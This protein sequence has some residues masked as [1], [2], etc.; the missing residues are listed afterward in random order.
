[1]NLEEVSG[2]KTEYLGIGGDFWFEKDGETVKRSVGSE[3][4]RQYF[5]SICGNYIRNK[6]GQY[7]GY[8]SE[9]GFE[10]R[11]WYN[12]KL[13]LGYDSYSVYV[14]G[15]LVR[16]GSNMSYWTFPTGTSSKDSSAVATDGYK[17]LGVADKLVFENKNKTNY[18]DNISVYSGTVINPAFT[19]D[20]TGYTGGRT[21]LPTATLEYWSSN[22]ANM[23]PETG[24]YGKSADD[25]SQKVE[26][27]ATNASGLIQLIAKSAAKDSFISGEDGSSILS[28]SFATDGKAYPY[29]TAKAIETAPCTID[30]VVYTS[31]AYGS[32]Q[33]EG[34]LLEVKKTSDGTY[35]NAFYED[36]KDRKS[37]V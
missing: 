18:I 37:V 3:Y 23:T 24:V 31:G 10:A 15:T 17:F 8:S 22:D 11:K 35:I 28:F 29:I 5:I 32:G 13:I 2:E 16:S 33:Y 20:F 25:I 7:A 30:G 1:M 27:A 21:G 12:I 34:N 26:G 14:D 9:T 6:V 36:H 19:I 4:Y